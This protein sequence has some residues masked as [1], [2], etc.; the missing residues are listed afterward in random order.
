M[1]KTL[2]DLILLCAITLLLGACTTYDVKRDA[3]GIVSVRVSST[4]SFDAPDLHY[5]RIDDDVQF[6]FKAKNADNNTD[7]FI[8]MFQGMMATM[9]QMLQ[10]MTA[11]PV[12]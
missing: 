4:R 2:M 12:K 10:A 3:E 1:K 5:K 6:D 9:M 7:A 11:A 8:G